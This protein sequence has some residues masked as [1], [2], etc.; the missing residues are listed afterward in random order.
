MP[1]AFLTLR[2][3]DVLR[4]I[5]LAA[6]LVLAGVAAPARAT[7]VQVTVDVPQGKT[8]TVRLRRLPKGAIVAVRIRTDRKLRIAFV[9]AIALKS[10]K[11][12]AL[13][14]GA[15]DRGITFRVTIPTSSDYYLVLDNRRGTQ[16]VKTRATIRAEKGSAPPKAPAPDKKKPKGS[17]NETRA[18]P[19]LRAT[20]ALRTHATVRTRRLLLATA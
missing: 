6:A 1:R 2:P 20:H 18:A 11:P 15:V 10:K 3:R 14:R 16:P 5:A 4:A 17:L 9:S 13:F 19:A 12:E 8:K 7:T